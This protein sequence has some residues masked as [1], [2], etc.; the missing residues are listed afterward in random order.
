MEIGENKFYVIPSVRINKNIAYALSLDN[1]YV[2]LSEAH[3]GNLG[4]MVSKCHK[5]GKKVIVNAELIGGLNLDK[6]GIN[7]LKKMYKVDGVISAN[8]PKAN[9]MK[10]IGLFTIQRVTLMDSKSL[11]TSLKLI[12]TSKCDAIEIRPYLYGLKFSDEI[13][14][15]RNVPIFLGGFIDEINMALKARERGFAG[16]TTSCMSLWDIKT[17]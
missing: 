12:S 6:T 2:L 9:M 8:T 4:P 5:N 16:I 15:A 13:K 11:D 3:I 14:K 7:M 10:D 17:K 1:E